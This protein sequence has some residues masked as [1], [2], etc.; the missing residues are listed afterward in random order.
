MTINFYTIGMAGHID[1]GKTTLTKALSGVDTD[2]LKEEKAR[3]IT[4]EPGFAPFPL[5][6]KIHT[7]IVDVPGHERLIRQMIAGVAGIDLVLLVIA[8]DEGVMPQTKEHFEILSFLKIHKGMIVVTKS[9]LVDDEMKLLIEEDILELTKDSVFQSFPV[10]YVDSVSM[11]GIDQLKKSI[12]KQLEDTETR[13]AIGPFRMPIDHIFSV[14]GQGTVVRGTVY[15][16]EVH[17]GDELEIQPGSEKVKVRKLQVHKENVHNAKAGQRAAINLSGGSKLDWKRGH[18]LLTPDVFTVTE[19]ID[20]VLTTGKEWSGKLKQRSSVK[21][22][23]GTAE[24]MG[25]LIFFDRNDL[26]GSSDLVFCQVRLNEAIVAKRGDRFIIRR[27]SPEETI[28]G[29]EVIDPNASRYKFGI[30]TVQMLQEKYKGTPGE[31]V[32]QTLQKNGSLMAGEL[33]KLTGI[34]NH[35]LDEVLQELIHEKAVYLINEFYMAETT[36]RHLERE[37]IKKL[38]AF[39][40][41]HPLRQGIPKAEVVQ[42]L[43]GELHQKVINGLIEMMVE[44]SAIRLTDQFIHLPAFTPHFPKKWEKRMSQA[45]HILEE[46]DL[47]PEELFTIYQNQ[48][49]PEDLYSDFKYYLI[50]N[51]KALVLQDDILISK[52]VF[53][54]AVNRLKNHTDPSFSVQEAKTVLNTSRKFLIPI[55]ECMDSK[56]YTVR[57]A[58]LRKWV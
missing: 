20:I 26:E 51:E 4:I 25:K 57:D 32:I 13:S 5:T 11:N 24:V 17:E 34:G 49:L 10:H 40:E 1:H 46:K 6:E 41:Q 12:A 48:Q 58:N 19:T 14:K 31:R 2:T 22:Y 42:S 45:I 39:H 33:K 16:G 15:E 54:S 21:F 35:T 38:A 37:L 50:K 47:E 43:K 9:D 30:Q 53:E 18:V 3:R 27:P 36:F 8:A 52:N 28:G 29:G 44:Y 23:T 56:G 55:L 7:S